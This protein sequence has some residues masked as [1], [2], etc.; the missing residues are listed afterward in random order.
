MGTSGPSQKL[1]SVMPYRH[2]GSWTFDDHERD[3]VAHPFGEGFQETLSF[4]SRIKAM[5]GVEAFRLTF[6]DEPFDRWD[7]ELVLDEVDDQGRPWYHIQGID[8]APPARM[9][10][11][12]QRYFPSPPSKLYFRIDPH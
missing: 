10:E 7:A 4:V 12:F 3:I 1:F 8:G 2:A 5:S 11:I 6:S 9:G